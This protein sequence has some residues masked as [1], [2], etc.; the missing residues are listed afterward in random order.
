MTVLGRYLD[1]VTNKD[2]TLPPIPHLHSLLSDDVEPYP[3]VDI[4]RLIRS[5]YEKFGSIRADLIEQMRFK[6]RLKVIQTLEDT[7]KRNVVR[8]IVTET[9]FTI[10]ELEELYALFKAE[11]LTSCYWGGNSNAI[12]RHDPSLP[13][14]E[15][16]R[17]DFEQF[18]GMFALL[19]PW[20]CG[21]HS[22]VLAARLFRLLDENGDLLINFREFVS[23]LSAACHGDLTEKL[24][25][26]YKM[27]VLPDPSPE[28][29][30]P[31]S[32]F[33]A[34]QYFFEDI[35]PECTHVVGLDSRNKQGVDDGF[36]TVS[37]KTD[38]GKKSSQENRNYLRMWSQENKS[39][40]KNSKDLPKLN[41]GQFI[42]LCKTMYNMFSED[43]NEQDL[44][45]A[46]AAVTSLLLEIGEVGK[47]F[48]VQPTKE[49]DSSSNSCSKAIQSEL[50]Q[51]KDSQQ[52]PLEQHKT[53]QGSLVTDDEQAICTESTLGMQMEDIKLE[54]SSPRDNGACSSMLISDDDTKDDSS[55]S[56]YSVL[57]AGSHEE[58]KLH[59]EDIGEDTVLVRSNHTTSLH[60]STSIDR[61]W[62]ITF[63]QFLASLLTEPAL[64]RYFDK[65]VSMMARIT[66]AKN[67]RMMGKPITS[68]SDYEI[69]TMSG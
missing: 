30:E 16:Y 18:K 7:T 44:Y 3:E 63:E 61:D 51:K 32:A 39:K 49:A 10:D 60:R 52:Y 14:L 23:G 62:A 28:Q 56:S 65:P 26:L 24:K 4:F 46:T 15:Q 34:T 55:M 66:N 11:H 27:H 9:S 37:L 1:S 47:L 58:E 40:A 53:F 35:T 67:V 2:S 5:S 31:D 45:H 33:E 42:E 21:T 54:D 13:Y 25:L 57:S 41:Q 36:V 68:A 43:P 20:A 38:K 12:D 59:C 17:I 6:Q 48:S 69:S 19:F 22:D 8:T 50:F 64:V 29:E